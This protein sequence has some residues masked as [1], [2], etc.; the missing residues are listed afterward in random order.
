MTIEHCLQ[1]KPPH[2]LFGWDNYIV[3]VWFFV[4]CFTD[5]SSYPPLLLGATSPLLFN[6]FLLSKLKQRHVRLLPI[7][8][9]GKL[10]LGDISSAEGRRGHPNNTKH[11]SVTSTCWLCHNS[12]HHFGQYEMIP[13][14]LNIVIP[15]PQTCLT[16]Y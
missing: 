9:S 3:L 13:I 14:F 16:P 4:G 10:T 5:C 1:G 15:A 11:Q 8:S 12:S 7:T 2:N 6:V